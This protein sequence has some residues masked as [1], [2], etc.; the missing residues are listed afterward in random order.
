MDAITKHHNE[1]P[2][3]DRLALD[4]A[5]LVKE[6]TE[7]AAL[8]PAEIRAIETD[9]EAG[10]YADT[11]ADIKAM[12]ERADASFEVE[13]K[14]WRDGGK[15]VDDFFSF[16]KTLQ[17]CFN[18]AKAALDARANLLLAQQRKAEAEAAEKARQEAAAELKRAQAEAVA[19]DEPPPVAA[20][21]AWVPPAPVREVARTVSLATGNKA[22][23]S[24]KWV[25]DV[26]DRAAVPREYLMV[27]D[28]AIKLAIKRGTT[29][30]GRCTLV[31][32]GIVIREEARTSIRR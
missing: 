16:R 23:A 13:K 7:A 6:A 8:V 19:F 18:R 24:V 9:E 31:I 30:D 17:A 21:I 26:T 2:L 25:H 15:T 3:A 29:K 32:P 20:P 10:A 22:S 11:A 12:I 4:H 28:D 27:D 1:P 5:E 14:P